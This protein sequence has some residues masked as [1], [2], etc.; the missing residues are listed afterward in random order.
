MNQNMIQCQNISESE[1]NWSKGVGDRYGNTTE[2]AYQGSGGAGNQGGSGGGAIWV[3]ASN[4]FSLDGVIEAK[5]GD[6]STVKGSTSGSGGGSGGSISINT[7][8]I[9]ASSNSIISVAGGKGKYGGGGG[10]GGWIYGMINSFNESKINLKST[11]EWNGIFNLSGGLSVLRKSTTNSNF[12]NINPADH[13]GRTGHEECAP[14]FEGVFCSPWVL[15]FYQIK[16]S[17]DPCQ[18]WK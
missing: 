18:A 6:S 17:T 14:G 16:T 15:G 12:N 8:N 3:H 7:A 4:V 2:K 9:S 5:G 13:L 11:I 10:S 1:A